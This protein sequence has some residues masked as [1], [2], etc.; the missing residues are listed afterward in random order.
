MHLKKTSGQSL[1]LGSYPFKALSPFL[2]AH[3]KVCGSFK[4]VFT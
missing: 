2:G 4:T 3:P 1:L